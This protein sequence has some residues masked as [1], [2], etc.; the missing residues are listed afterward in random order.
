MEKQNGIPAEKTGGRKPLFYAAWRQ[1]SCSSG[2]AA[3]GGVAFGIAAFVK[4]GMARPSHFS[5]HFFIL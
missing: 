4:S 5:T 3:G 2:A 1:R